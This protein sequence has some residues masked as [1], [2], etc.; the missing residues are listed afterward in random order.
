MPLFQPAVLRPDRIFGFRLVLA[1][2]SFLMCE[3]SWADNVKEIA[4]KGTAELA[5][6]KTYCL[7]LKYH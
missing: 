2:V 1:L 6:N 3:S 5:V 7:Y 4:G